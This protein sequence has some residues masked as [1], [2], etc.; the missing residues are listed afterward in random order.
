MCGSAHSAHPLTYSDNSDGTITD[1]VTGYLAATGNAGEIAG[2]IGALLADPGLRA[3][4]GAAAREDAER[5]FD[6]RRNV[7]ELIRL[8]GIG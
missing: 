2:N 6:L 5:R 7:A 3:R 4:M 1:G 8:Y